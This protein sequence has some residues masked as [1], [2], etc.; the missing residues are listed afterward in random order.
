[1]ALAPD[2]ENHWDAVDEA[3]VP[4]SASR[5]AF[6]RL[7]LATCDMRPMTRISDHPHPVRARLRISARRRIPSCEFPWHQERLLVP[8]LVEDWLGSHLEQQHFLEDSEPLCEH[9]SGLKT[10]VQ[11][12][13]VDLLDKGLL[14]LT[15]Q[16][17]VPVTGY[18][19]SL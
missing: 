14:D 6:S 1:M 3:A 4:S 18:K 10:F 7:C 5:R 11:I 13:A 12:A 9:L 19:S 16:S 17:G 15:D 8:L 2:R